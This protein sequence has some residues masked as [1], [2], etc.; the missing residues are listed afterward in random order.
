MPTFFGV[1]QHATFFGHYITL[2]SRWSECG[3]A[4][5]EDAQSRNA[6]GFEN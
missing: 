4:A 1:C 5:C 2:T 6:A 3:H